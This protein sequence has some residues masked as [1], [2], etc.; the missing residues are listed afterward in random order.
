MDI[1]KEVMKGLEISKEEPR[2]EK[3]AAKPRRTKRFRVMAMVV[4]AVVLAMS[5]GAVYAATATP[6]LAT[7]DGSGVLGDGNRIGGRGH[8]MGGLGTSELASAVTAGTI[9]QAESDAVSAYLSSDVYA[10]LVKAG[11]LTQAKADALKA[12]AIATEA[13]HRTLEMTDRL[14]A[15][16]TAGTLTQ[17][18]SDAVL[19][20][21]ATQDERTALAALVTAGTLTQAQ[22]DAL[23]PAFGHGGP[24]GHGGHGGPR[25]GD[26]DG[27]CPAATTPAVTTVA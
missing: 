26:I 14:A 7:A 5:F 16:V 12:S 25:G 20:A 27:E 24:G 23:V 18:Q 2:T 1:E 13:A 15:A 22:S 8:G 3:A 9:T 17:A 11:V 21:V 6:T 4:A 19:A 10:Q